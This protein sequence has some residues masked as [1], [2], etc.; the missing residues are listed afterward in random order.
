MKGRSVCQHCGRPLPVSRRR[1]TCATVCLVMGAAMSPAAGVSQPSPRLTT[2]APL[3]IETVTSVVIGAF[4]KLE[5]TQPVF[6]ESGAPLDRCA[7]L[8]CFRA[9][10]TLRS[11]S[12]WQ[13]Q[14]R[15]APTVGVT[16]P[17]SWWPTDGSG[18]PVSGTW[19]AIGDGSTPTPGVPVSLRF[20]A[21]G[22]TSQRP[23]AVGLSSALQF[24]VVP[25]P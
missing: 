19:L 8:T 23:D 21:G 6:A 11:N 20:T 10:V 16:A 25:L 7:P 24:R 22:P 14:V 13:L 17:I 1:A 5:P 9:T 3:P 12:R 18:L 2:G 15:L 4:F